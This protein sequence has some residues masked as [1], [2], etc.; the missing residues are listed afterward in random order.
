MK[1]AGLILSCGR[2]PLASGSSQSLCLP[3]P[4]PPTPSSDTLIGL[5]SARC[6]PVIVVL[7]AAADEIRAGVRGDA[8][9][10]YNEA[11][12]RTVTDQFPC[13]AAGAWRPQD[14]DGVLFT[15]VDHPA[16]SSAHHRRP[17]R[18]RPRP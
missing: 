13:N 9:F 3:F 15:L 1:A 18:N 16:V 7:G 2:I 10:V 11:Y 14:A 5:F 4:Q 17:A 12:L 6:S 8:I